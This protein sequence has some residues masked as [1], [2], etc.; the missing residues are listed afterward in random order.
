VKVYIVRSVDRNYNEK[1]RGIFKTYEDAEVFGMTYFGYKYY[2]EEYPVRR[3]KI[4]DM[5]NPGDKDYET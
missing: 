1:I 5:S 3:F 2:V 4:S